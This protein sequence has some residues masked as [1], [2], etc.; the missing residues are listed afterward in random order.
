[1]VNYLV[2]GY[3]LMLVVLLYIEVCDVIL[4]VVYVVDFEDYKLILG[5]FVKCGMGLGV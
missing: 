3:K 4:V 5:V 2:V 1:M